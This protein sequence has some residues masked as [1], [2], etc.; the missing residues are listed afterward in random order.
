MTVPTTVDDLSTTAADNNP[1]GGQAVSPL[2]DNHIRA[3]ASFIA[4]QRDELE[5][6]AQDLQVVNNVLSAGTIDS[7]GVVGCSTAL[8]TIFASGGEWELPAGTYLLDATVYIPDSLILRCQSGA[9]FKPASNSMTM[10]NTK[11]YSGTRHAYFAQIHN[12]YLDATGKTGVV[13]F[14]MTGFR[15]AAGIFFPV[16]VGPFDHCIKL[17]ELCWDCIIE[18]PFAQG[19][20]NGILIAHGSN[21][22][23]VRK[24]GIDGLGSAGYGIKVIGGALYPSTSNIVIGGYVQG[25]SAGGGIGCWDSGSGTAVG[26]YGTT[27]QNVY[28]ELNEFADIYFDQSYYGRAIGCEHY[29]TFGQNGI[30]ARDCD[31]VR[32]VT[33][34]MTSGSRSVGLYNFDTSNAN[35]YGDMTSSSGLGLNLPMGTISGLGAIPTEQ[36]GD[37]PSPGVVVESSG[38]ASTGITYATRLAKWHRIG[39][40]VTLSIQVKWSGWT[41]P[42]GNV[43]IKGAPVALT[44]SSFSPTGVGKVIGLMNWSG[45][46]LVAYL[47]GSG[48]NILVAQVTTGGTLTPLPMAAIGELVID[49]SYTV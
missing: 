17:T 10:F 20:I 14:D 34:L 47:N 6:V 15:H 1:Q 49:L 45:A 28:F 9:I 4:E 36:W 39:Q 38:G 2:L 43:L 25:F 3:L 19:C 18:E 33:P 44:A 13:G 5:G 48:T 22:V 12:A 37:F 27:F 32:V 23:Q 35:C 41:G 24:P 42:A 31:G 8:N 40:R 29:V 46:D 30:F 21:A 7:T 26:V 16:F 11:D